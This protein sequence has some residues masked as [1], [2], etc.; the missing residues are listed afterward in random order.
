LHEHRVPVRL[1]P[2]AALGPFP[3][4]SVLGTIV[5][6]RLLTAVVLF[7]VAP[8][9]YGQKQFLALGKHALPPHNGWTTAVAA[10]DVDGDGDADLVCAE[11]GQARLY[12]NDGAGVFSDATDQLPASLVPTTAVALAD[13]DGD[14]DLDLFLGTYSRNL[15]YFN[16]GRGKFTDVS[17]TRLPSRWAITDAVVVA[18][19]DGDGDADLLTGN[20][21]GLSRFGRGDQN[22]LYL[23]DGKGR[24]VDATKDRLPSR[25]DA[26]RSLAVGDVDGDHDLD[27]V[28]GNLDEVTSENRIYINDGRGRFVE[29]SQSLPSDRDTT[30]AVAL[31]DVDGDG[32]LDLVVGNHDDTGQRNRLYLNDGKGTFSDATS[33]LPADHDN[34]TSI[35]L[36]DVDRDGDLDLVFGNDLKAEHQARVSQD[37]VLMND[38]KGRFTDETSTRLGRLVTFTEAVVLVDVDADGAL[39]L[40]LGSGLRGNFTRFGGQ[41][42]ILINDGKGQ[43]TDATALQLPL[44]YGSAFAMDVGDVDG[45]GDLDLVF[46]SRW[47]NRLFENDGKGSFVEITESAV[48]DDPNSTA[49]VIL[50]DVDGDGDLDL[51]AANTGETQPNEQNQLYLND[52]KGRFTNATKSSLPP[53]SVPT[54][55]AAMDDLDGDGDIDLICGNAGE[56]DRLYLN[57]GHG[58]FSDASSSAF[59][60]SP[61]ATT[62]IAVGDLDGDGDLDVVLAKATE[63]GR[64]RVFLNDGKARFTDATS[65]SLPE[66]KGTYWS[67]TLG[68]ADGDG[69]LDVVF[70]GNTRLLLNDGKAK[71]TDVTASALPGVGLSSDAAFGDLDRDGDPDLVF[72]NNNVGEGMQNKVF[73]NDGKARFSDA[74][75]RF[76]VEHSPTTAV[77]VCDVDGDGDPDLVFANFDAAHD[78][79]LNLHRQIH[80]P[81]LVKLGHDYTIDYY[82]TPGYATRFTLV[83]PFLSTAEKKRETPFGTFGLDVA[84]LVIAPIR[85]I[86]PAIGKA[87][88]TYLVPND[89]RL[90]G[91]HIVSQ[92][93]VIDDLQD[94]VG[95]WRL[96]NVHSDRVR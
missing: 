35:A 91:M 83:V 40:V 43:F 26:T 21:G 78:L 5:V 3:Y 54:G 16:D 81:Q 10:G 87:T 47:R 94:P 6:T 77:R 67:V 1:L 57:D 33:S 56:P 42:R 93:L 84:N 29:S 37:R 25:K 4:S 14:R 80:T 23:N 38:G 96:T 2:R 34:T 59:P 90:R 15:I 17:A 61:G 28:V 20:G 50:A 68:D 71:F 51:F 13:L 24:F 49:C 66:G 48:P 60:S 41:D 46:G 89:A 72:A 8:L 45:D 9:A 19:I 53:R 39:D 63:T 36:G 75:H 74:K 76:P 85:V 86:H 55:S 64:N 30:Y 32:D 82:A 88:S 31:G 11:A 65:S 52:G 69:D 70:S 22:G 27:L 58:R 95:H 18:D 92:A 44:T 12:L 79:Y 73:L 62:G 7:V